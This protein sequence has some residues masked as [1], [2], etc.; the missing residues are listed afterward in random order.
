MA[1]VLVED[2]SRYRM[3]DSPRLPNTLC[4]DSSEEPLQAVRCLNNLQQ[5]CA[6]GWR[7]FDDLQQGCDVL[8]I[9]ANKKRKNLQ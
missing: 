2:C 6:V 1:S 5:A 3:S 7:V 9:G 8:L 4:P